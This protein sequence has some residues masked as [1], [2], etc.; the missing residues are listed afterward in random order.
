MEDLR[1]TPESLHA[2]AARLRSESARI[3]AA[4]GSLDAEVT[5]LRGQWEGA[6]QSAYDTAQRQWTTTLE[7]MRDVLS[8]IANATDGIADDYVSTDRASATRF[9]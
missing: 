2:A 8:R 9:H 5:R 7:H 4:L 3:D 6:A 1:V